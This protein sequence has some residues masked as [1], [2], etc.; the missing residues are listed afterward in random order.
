MPTIYVDDKAH[1]VDAGQNVLQ[2]CLSLGYDLEYFCWHPALGS[3]GA[4]RQCAV[5]QFKG[6]DDER[7]KLV[8]ACM[9]PAKDGTRVSLA[10]SQ[11]EQMRAST[12]EFLM[13]NH[14]HDCPV[15][16]EGGECHLQDM[17]VMSGHNYRRY[18]FKKR[19]YR[20]QDLGPFIHHEMNRCIQCYRCVRFY[21][22]HADGRDLDV[23]GLN[24]RTF[25]GREADGVLENEF[26]GNLVEVC[27]TGVF[28]DKTFKQHFTRK[29][30]LQ[31]APSVCHLCSLGC[32]ITP[33]ERYE[34]L[35][36]VRNRYNR[37]VNGYF[38]C[39]RGRFGYEFV[40]AEDRVRQPIVREWSGQR[41][42]SRAQDMEVGG[43]V[44]MQRLTGL[45]DAAA[46]GEYALIGVGSPRASLESNFA[47]RSVVGAER[48][49][50]GMSEADFRT[51]RAALRVMQAAPAPP[52]S[53]DDVASAQAVLVLGEDLTNTAPR[54]A[55]AVRQ[56]AKTVP[57][58]TTV[59][60]GTPAWNAKAVRESM[61]D[62]R[63]PVYLTT[64]GRT[65]LEDIATDA[66]HAAPADIARLGFAVA[67]ALDDEAPR[68][69]GLDAAEGAWAGAVADALSSV[70]R[71]VVIGGTHTGEPAV[72]DAA[73]SVARALARRGGEARLA[74]ALGECNSLGLLML[75]AKPLSQAF[76]AVDAERKTTALVVENDLYRRVDAEQ[77]RT[78]VDAL[79]RLICLDHSPN[80]TNR[81]ADM[82]LPAATFAEGSGTLVSNEGRAQ[83]FF[84]V[85]TPDGPVG[86]SWRWLAGAMVRAGRAE[87]S[88]WDHL[89]AV[90]DQIAEAF[91]A[92]AGIRRAAHGAEFRLA[93]QRVPRQSARYSGRTAMHADQSVHEPAPP[94]DEDSPLS[95]SMEGTRLQPPADL[96]DRVWAP[97][98][99]SVQS[100]NK[101]Q[102]EIAGELAGGPSGHRLFDG[103]P[104]AAASY[105][106][107]I[108]RAFEPRND[109]FLAVPRYHI[110]GSEPLS[111]RAP[112][113]AQRVAEPRVYLQPE[114][115]ASLGLTA[116]Q[117]VTLAAD[118]VRFEMPVQVDETIPRGCVGV[119]VGLPA[120]EQT[121]AFDWPAWVRVEGGSHA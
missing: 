118:E 47:L 95:F 77:V 38:I 67:A 66:L 18:R 88:R 33:G 109:A 43:E 101:F 56:A 111:A 46:A 50:A 29:W 62:D 113:V 54:L 76:D 89:D 14:P 84:R 52:A 117:V 82:V 74:L 35:R 85:C 53:L 22:D 34:T 94:I 73:A 69:D 104:P 16:D 93:G 83:R 2:A 78:F 31:T 36:R 112:A 70:E 55:L 42:R 40:N 8:M 5:K 108:P 80:P 121:A 64:T 10:D 81:L 3:V 57:T 79:D 48:F 15:C 60:Q 114:A 91:P 20:N 27:P 107:D 98:W 115:L 97:G 71:V 63:G 13:T 41:R 59:A 86:E 103:A 12:I 100:L 7:G 75:G 39:D 25:F 61:Q 110:F 11:A 32:N 26:S 44:A 87:Q 4:C 17:T 96:V 65:K 45:V 9:T 105:S 90:V 68:V 120:A 19:V 37:Q 119:S 116:G 72:V 49:Y 21:R 1:E 51:T 92:L 6:A 58:E 99:N 30:D 23:F 24:G 102:E 28:T 106:R